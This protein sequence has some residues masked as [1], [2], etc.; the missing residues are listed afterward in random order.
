M[1]NRYTTVSW[2]F[3]GVVVLDVGRVVKWQP[4]A[5]LADANSGFAKKTYDAVRMSRLECHRVLGRE[6]HHIR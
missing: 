3:D 2:N 6:I 4:T 5:F 1:L